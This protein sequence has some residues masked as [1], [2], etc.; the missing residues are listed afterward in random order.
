MIHAGIYQTE[1]AVYL[2]F[3]VHHIMTD[4][5]GMHLLNEDIVRAF[6]GEALPL[7]TYYAYLF[8]QEELRESKKYRDDR[9][10]L[11]K[12]YGQDD[13]CFQF[14][15]DVEKR[16]AGRVILPLKRVV[17]LEEI[18]TFE[19]KHHVSR[20]RLF[21][22]AAL[23]GMAAVEKKNRVMLNWV[24]HDRTDEVRKNAFGCVFR[25]VTVGVEITKDM[26]LGGFLK[27]VSERSNESLAHYSYEWSLKRNN[28][29]DHDA[30]FIVYETAE[31]MSS[32]DIGSIGGTRLNVGS[33]AR[34]NTFTMAIQMIENPD[35]I[36]TYLVMNQT[37]F[38]EQKMNRM[39]D[40]FS[41]LVDTILKAEKPDQIM[42][43]DCLTRI[44]AP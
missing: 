25:Y 13:W 2:F 14:S 3:E 6:H 4:G 37:I 26:T 44:A 38:S 17:G 28:V 32:N 21:T 1:E 41:G 29:Y 16:P 30:L 22:A 5:T 36:S 23:L 20:N 9:A 8:H 35:G 15:P 24:Y 18:K 11:E 27:A 42:L 34:F 19:E 39:V 7:D 33:H 12:V 40:V 10:F 43:S 31:I